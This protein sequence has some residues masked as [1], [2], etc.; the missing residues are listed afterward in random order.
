[1]GGKLMGA[2]GGGFFMFYC[3]NGSRPAVTEALRKMGLRR[4]RF[5]ID[6]DGAKIMLN[7][8]QSSSLDRVRG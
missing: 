1:M 7:T 2:G 8:R 5:Q 6:W 3:Q 4:E